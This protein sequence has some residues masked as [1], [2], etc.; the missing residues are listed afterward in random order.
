MD[1]MTRRKPEKSGEDLL[2][3][4]DLRRFCAYFHRLTGISYSDSKRFF[5]ERRIAERMHQTGMPTFAAYM[6]TLQAN[7]SEVE[8]LINA[9][10]VNETYY[11]REDGHLRCLSNVLLPDIARTRGPGDL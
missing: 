2:S 1:F 5:I 3:A 7:G 8:Q 4:S 9:F 6:A 11:Y 10:T